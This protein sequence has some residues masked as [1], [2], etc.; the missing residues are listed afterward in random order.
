VQLSC[1]ARSWWMDAGHRLSGAAEGAQR[2][3]G[4]YE[5]VSIF[6]SEAPTQALLAMQLGAIE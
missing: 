3:R 4:L 6:R 1:S 2:E 5:G